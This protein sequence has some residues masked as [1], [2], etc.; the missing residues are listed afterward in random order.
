ML[1]TA[2]SWQWE[3]STLDVGV[4]HWCPFPCG[5]C[6][7]W[8]THW[9]TFSSAF[10]VFFYITNQRVTSRLMVWPIC[11]LLQ[12]RGA[13][14][15]FASWCQKRG[16]WTSSVSGPC[17]AQTV[18]KHHPPE[19]R[20]SWSQLLPQSPAP[21]R[22]TGIW[23]DLSPCCATSI[24]ACSQTLAHF[25]SEFWLHFWPLLPLELAREESLLCLPTEACMVW[26]LGS[27]Y[28]GRKGID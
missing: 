15:I 3:P 5:S 8:R 1:F 4:F 20:G 6:V 18:P 26:D 10:R 28:T 2:L 16:M 9:L 24:P 7:N 14:F 19:V 21:A 13:G 25:V 23:V 17:T 12:F 22:L 11:R 27:E